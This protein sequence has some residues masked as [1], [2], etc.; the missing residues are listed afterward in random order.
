MNQTGDVQDQQAVLG[1]LIIGGMPFPDEFCMLEDEC[2][3]GVKEGYVWFA[4]QNLRDAGEPVDEVTVCHELKRI[5]CAG[6]IATYIA[7]ITERVP[8]LENAG[9]WMRLL[10][11][12]GRKRKIR[13]RVASAMDRAG[14]DA[15]AE[16]ISAAVQDAIRQVDRETTQG[17]T[18]VRQIMPDVLKQIT[19]AVLD[20]DAGR[21]AKTGIADLDAKTRLG[22]G[23]LTVIAGR[24]GMGKSALAGNIASYCAGRGLV[25]LFSL[26]MSA[27]DFVRRMIQSRLHRDPVEADVTAVKQAA[28]S[29]SGI[30][31]YIDDAPGL[32]VPDMSGAL[33]KLGKPSLVVVDYLQLT[34]APEA[35]RNDL[36]VGAVT[37]ALKALAKDFECHVIVLCQL[38]RA[39]EATSDKR[40]QMGHLRDSG[41]IEE[42]ADNVWLLF[43]EDYYVPNK[44]PGCAEIIIG[45][46]RH[47][48]TGSVA[49][50][51]LPKAQLFADAVRNTGVDDDH[52]ERPGWWTR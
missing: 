16:S 38:N 3:T 28:A 47:G 17:L 11:E 14:E 48:Q 12:D 37:K 4:L 21:I 25:A 51:W 31:L 39:V 29:L 8:S 7:E 13:A 41:N 27:V 5:G 42:D 6:N 18:H 1:A 33:K 10:A 43:R 44:N 24:P 35:E 49:V 2:F 32:S 23:Q 22:A 20:P 34:K 46:Q 26:E 15:D 9:H 45:K 36:R 40:P 19:D 52:E 30:E 50:T